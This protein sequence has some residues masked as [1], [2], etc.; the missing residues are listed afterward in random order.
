MITAA[1][2][3]CI[4]PRRG[5]PPSGGR[6]SDELAAPCA[7]DGWTI[8]VSREFRLKSCHVNNNSGALL[9]RV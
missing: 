7:S 1:L 6:T 3:L 9:T 8:D 4:L 2:E 5:Q